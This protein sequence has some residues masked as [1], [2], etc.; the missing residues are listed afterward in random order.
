MRTDN[1]Y[2]TDIPTQTTYIHMK[3]THGRDLADSFSAFWSIPKV[4]LKQEG[5]PEKLVSDACFRPLLKK[6]Y[7]V[8]VDSKEQILRDSRMR[9]EVSS[10]VHTSE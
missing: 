1:T 9:N 5:L 4:P 7:T 10:L 6:T 8:E 2:I 3:K